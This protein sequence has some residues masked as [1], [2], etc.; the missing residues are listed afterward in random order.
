MIR[1]LALV[2]NKLYISPPQKNALIIP[3]T[4]GYTN[5]R[6]QD[7]KALVDSGATESFMDHQT[8]E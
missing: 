1:V 7:A 4:L 3:I 5:E 2:L 6:M 8:A